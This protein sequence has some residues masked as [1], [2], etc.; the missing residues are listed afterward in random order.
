M[1]WWSRCKNCH[2][3]KPFEEPSYVSDDKEGVC[4]RYPQTHIKRDFD[5]CGEFRF[6]P[7]E[8]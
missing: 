4:Y 3:F 7:E 2:Y 1:K 6:P 5:C 8:I